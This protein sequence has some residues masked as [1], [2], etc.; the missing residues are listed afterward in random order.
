MPR[1]EVAPIIVPPTN[2]LDFWKPN[3]FVTQSGINSES[4][5]TLDDL[6]I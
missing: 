4:I 5:E 1:T 2:C 3:D 6:D